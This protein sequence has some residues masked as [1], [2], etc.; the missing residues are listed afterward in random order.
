MNNFKILLKYTLIN[1]LGLNKLQKKKNGQSRNTGLGVLITIILL[2]ILAVVTLYMFMFTEMFA[3][4]GDASLV[5]LFIYFV[6]SLL[7][8][9]TTISKANV[10]IFRTKDYDFLMS[11]PIKPSLI[12][13]T[14]LI[15]LYLYNLLFVVVIVLGTDIAYTI[16]AGFSAKFL[17][18]TIPAILL[19]PLFP[20]MVSSFLSFLLGFIPLKQKVKNFISTLLYVAIIVGIG[21]IYFLS[22]SDDPT[23]VI[24]VYTKMGRFYFMSNWLYEG[25]N[26]LDIVKI[27]LFVGISIL[28]ALVFVV[29]VSRFFLVLNGRMNNYKTNTNYKLSNEKFSKSG[30]VKAIFVK[31]IRSLFNYPSVLVQVAS[32]PLLSLVLAISMMFMMKNRISVEG[33]TTIDPNTMLLIAG[34]MAGM[35]L[36]MVA[37]TSS[38][39]SLEGK[40][41]WILKSAP[42]KTKNVFIA[43]CLVN[44]IFTVPFAII[45]VVI[46]ALLA[47]SDLLISA[48]VLVLLVC[49]ILFATFLGLNL[50]ISNPKFDYDN[51]VKAVKQG[52]AV[53]FTMLIDMGVTILL[54]L[55]MVLMGAFVGLIYA[56]LVGVVITVILAVI[57]GYVLFTSSIIKYN[58]LSA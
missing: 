23:G 15:S 42:I 40:S 3:L 2:A 49:Y 58:K 24:G 45:D 46:I 21:L 55:S 16:L 31:D 54:A 48:L 56:A 44:I 8:F 34:M 19:I 57:S 33:G 20:M 43:K 53:L 4:A 10:Y 1:N 39:I 5:F 14:K 50:N 29:V 52:K 35:M 38:T 18:A 25:V 37:T 27:L 36:T 17:I 47:K 9:I 32:G 22:M 51:P 13:T 12:I 11:L 41:F 26:N 30:D 7:C 6:G 28:S